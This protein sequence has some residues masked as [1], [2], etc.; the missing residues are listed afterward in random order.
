MVVKNYIFIIIRENYDRLTNNNFNSC[1]AHA[2]NS[3]NYFE[4][5]NV[6]FWQTKHNHDP[7][8]NFLRQI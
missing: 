6:F 3:F 5:S 1:K 4:N 8:L 2:K 7:Y